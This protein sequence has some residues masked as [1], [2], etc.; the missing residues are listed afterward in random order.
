MGMTFLTTVFTGGILYAAIGFKWDT[1]EIHPRN[2]AL[3]YCV[4]N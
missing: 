4:K 1:S 2:V 3:L